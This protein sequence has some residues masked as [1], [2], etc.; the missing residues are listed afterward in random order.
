[1]TF[2]YGTEPTSFVGNVPTQKFISKMRIDENNMSNHLV[3]L[4]FFKNKTF[5]RKE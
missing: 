2:G 5:Q 1:M 3:V 4:F